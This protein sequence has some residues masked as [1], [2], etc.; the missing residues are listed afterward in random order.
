MLIISHRGN[1]L[2]PNPGFENMPGK[3]V[4][5]TN[6]YD[7]EIDVWVNSD[8]IFL[9]HDKPEHKVTRDF[10]YNQRL[11]CH[12]KNLQALESLL[13]V[14]AKCFFHNIDDYTLTSNGLIWTY[15]DKPVTEKSIIVDVT[16]GWRTKKYHCFGVC[17]DYVL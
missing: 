15:P 2:G 16:R 4:E 13:S 14:N 17:V 6:N 3:I 11:W 5:V 1:L 10:F 7:C 8:G 12:A 9:G